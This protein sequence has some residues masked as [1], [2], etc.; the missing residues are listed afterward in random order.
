LRSKQR[1]MLVTILCIIGL[2]LSTLIFLSIYNNRNHSV[3]EITNQISDNPNF[4][5]VYSDSMKEGADLVKYSLKGE[6]INKQKLV[7]GQALYYFTKFNSDYYIASERKNRHYIMD[8]SGKVKS[9]FGPS[10]YEEDRII[11]SSF[12]KSNEKYLFFSM[13]VGI[14]PDYSPKEYSNELIYSEIGTSISHHIML[15]GYF[16]SVVERDNKAYVLYFNGTDN[17]VG[18]Y[19]I[20]LKTSKMIKDFTIDNH[21]T[22]EQG[23]YPVG[24]NNGSSLQIFQD[25]LIVMLDG[26]HPDI[27]Y[28][29]I[30]QIINPENG[31]MEKEIK[32]SNEPFSIYD[33]QVYDGKLYV[34]SNDGS[35]IIWEDLIKQART[36]KLK[37]ST[38]F[39]NKKETERGNVSGFEITGNSIFIL[40]DFVKNI[41]VDRVREIRRY[42]LE[43]GNEEAV[44]PL[45][46]RSE[47]EMIRFFTI[48]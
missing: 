33:T 37:E 1:T 21:S 10:N 48:V 45:N 16:Q 3:S 28:Q 43:T 9:F 31:I 47:K 13:N 46:Y 5:V 8:R 12:V 20:D 32:I 38:E 29:P 14:N 6:I 35:V 39:I 34:L 30:M 23:Y 24:Q 44:I 11:G 42:N 26:N 25:R 17:S 19:V 18:I 41:P 40:Y 36:L 27:Q 7:E 15:P 2:F 4:V 22:E